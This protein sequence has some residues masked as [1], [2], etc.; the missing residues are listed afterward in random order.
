[1]LQA[2]WSYLFSIPGSAGPLSRGQ[3]SITTNILHEQV[4]RGDNIR[5][6]GQGGNS[7]IIPDASEYTGARDG[8]SASHSGYKAKL[9]DL[10]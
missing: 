8:Q 9:T 1:M 7:R 5:F 10:S 2:K 6:R 3:R 4:N